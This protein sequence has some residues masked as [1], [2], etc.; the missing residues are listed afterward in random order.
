M[1]TLN[2]SSNEVKIAQNVCMIHD[3]TYLYA[4]IQQKAKARSIDYNFE[5]NKLES[6]INWISLTDY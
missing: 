4:Q 6:L 1:S 5:S 2:L 3:L